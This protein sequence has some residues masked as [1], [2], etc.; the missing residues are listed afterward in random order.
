[1][2]FLVIDNFLVDQLIYEQNSFS[3]SPEW[4]TL[5]PS[6]GLQEGPKK[7]ISTAMSSPLLPYQ[8]SIIK[9]TCQKKIFHDF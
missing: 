9:N 4:V 7:S 2:T 5:E 6:P 8:I 3:R 1:M